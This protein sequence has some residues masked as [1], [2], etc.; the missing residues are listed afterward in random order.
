MEPPGQRILE[1][2]HIGRTANAVCKGCICFMSPGD[3][4]LCE[5]K[6]T[7]PSLRLDKLF[8]TASACS[9]F[10]IL[11]MTLV[12]VAREMDNFLQR[13]VLHVRPPSVNISDVIEIINI[14]L[15][16]DSVKLENE[17]RQTNII[18]LEGFT[19]KWHILFFSFLHRGIPIDLSLCSNFH[20]SCLVMPL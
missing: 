11:A 4:V 19:S 14:I 18:F 15:G 16:N 10:I 9:G 12:Q 2:F 13:P 1:K 3:D 6:E 7:A 17:K 20:D 5:Q 8:C